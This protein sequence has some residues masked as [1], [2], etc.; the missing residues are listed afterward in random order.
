LVVG[1]FSFQPTTNLPSVR[2]AIEGLR[3]V[4]YPPVFTLNSE[5]RTGLWAAAAT[6]RSEIVRSVRKH[7][8]DCCRIMR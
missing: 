3:G 2:T 6:T 5:V 4:M 1:A 7:V 8:Q